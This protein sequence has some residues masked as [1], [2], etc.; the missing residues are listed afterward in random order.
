MATKKPTFEQVK[1]ALEDYCEKHAGG[2]GDLIVRKPKDAKAY[3]EY[4]SDKAICWVS[5]DGCDL[6]NIVNF[7]CG[8]KAFDAFQKFM[9]DLGCWFELGNA[10]NFNVFRVGE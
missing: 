1:K 8:V 6:Y 4:A 10:W 7:H 2:K 5:V 3:S 9:D